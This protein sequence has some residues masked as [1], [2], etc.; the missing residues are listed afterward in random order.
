MLIGL[1]GYAGS[2]KDT[3]ASFLIDMWGFERRAFAD[4]LKELA[5]EHNPEIVTHS[6][7][8]GRAQLK[9]RLSVLVGDL[10]WECAKREIPAVREYLQ[11]LGIDKREI[12]E[13]YWVD[14]VLPRPEHLIKVL[15]HHPDT[16]RQ[17]PVSRTVYDK[18]CITDVRFPNEIERIKS[19]GGT[20]VRVDRP[21][22]G[23]VNDHISET[24]W[25]GSE[26]YV[27]KNHGGLEHL[28][29]EVD[30]LITTL[31]GDYD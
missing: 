4:K 22:V 14:R 20:I 5:L 8:G 10:G 27:I 3:V 13:D 18:L 19:L 25:L 17:W 2:G 15:Y 12:D 7:L 29:S 21:G 16:W 31:R 1:T 28:E 24:A 23:P 9:V 6:V 30:L 26:S 11:G